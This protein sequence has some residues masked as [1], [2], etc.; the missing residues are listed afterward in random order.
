MNGGLYFVLIPV[1][2]PTM[3]VRVDVTY[4]KHEPDVVLTRRLA[5][6]TIKQKWLASNRTHRREDT[7]AVVLFRTY[8]E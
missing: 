2:C 6:E 4:G 3:S 5:V 1:D 8:S 7:Q